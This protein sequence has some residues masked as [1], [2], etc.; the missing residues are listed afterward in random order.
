MSSTSG[1]ADSESA[2][3]TFYREVTAATPNS[4]RPDPEPRTP[5]LPDLSLRRRHPAHL[6][7]PTPLRLR[8]DRRGLRLHVCVLHHPDAARLVSQPD[9]G[10]DRS[11]SAQLAAA[12]R[13]RAAADLAG[14]DLLR[15][16]S[17]RTR[18]AGAAAA[19]AERDRGAALDQAALPLPHDHHGRRARGDGRLREGVPLHR[20]AAAARVGRGA[21]ADAAAGQ[22]ADVRHAVAED[23]RPRAGRHAADD[24][25]R[26]LPGRDRGRTSPSWRASSA[27]PRFDHLGV[28]TYSHEEGTRAFALADDVPAAVKRRRRNALDGASKEDSGV[29]PARRASGRRSACSSTAHRPSTRWCVQGRLEGQAPDIDSVVYFTECDPAALSLETSSR[30][31]SSPPA[32]TTWLSPRRPRRQPR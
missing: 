10:I 28:F 26:R 30:L 27:R 24:V 13:A 18:R 7:T 2:R 16:R 29:R 6:T 5:T 21:Q 15:H 19:R 4:R 22:P 20:P 11:G 12:R 1:S 8:Q 31:E 32:A 14:H 23:P 17:R 3:S 9:G 25:D